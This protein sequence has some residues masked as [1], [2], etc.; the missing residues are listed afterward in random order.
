[1]ARDL[2]EA[3][4]LVVEKG[5]GC[6]GVRACP[7]SG[8]TFTVAARLARYLTSWEPR[9]AGVAALSFTNVAW[10]EIE[11][12]LADEFGLAVP[13]GYPHYLGT[14][15][16]FLNQFIFLPH[17]HRVLGCEKRPRMTGPPYDMREPSTTW[18]PWGKGNAECYRSCHLLDFSYDVTGELRNFSPRSGFAN[19]TKNHEPCTQRKGQFSRAG[20]ATQLDA[21]YYSLTLLANN[22]SLAAALARRFPV[23]VVDEAQDSSAIQMRVLELLADAGLDELLLVGDPDQAIY[24]WRTAD[25]AL[26]EAKLVQWQDES[27]A[28]SDSWR[29]TE[30]LCQSFSRFCT[31]GDPITSVNSDLPSPGKAPE[32]WGYVQ[33]ALPSL[34]ERFRDACE[35]EGVPADRAAVLCRSKNLV[36]ELLGGHQGKP[37]RY[38]PW[39]STFGRSLAVSALQRDEGETLAAF[40]SMERTLAK[41]MLNTPHV[42]RQVLREIYENRGFSRWRS[43]VWKTLCDLP[44]VAGCTLGTWIAGAREAVERVGV[45]DG[46]RVEILADSSKNKYSDLSI[47]QALGADAPQA[48][49]DGIRIGTVHSF[50]G[51]SIEAV[52]LVL[53][54]RAANSKSYEKLL[55][56]QLGVDEEMRIVY[57]AMT[58]ARSLLY[59]AVPD[60]QTEIWENAL[61]V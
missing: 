11:A 44:A 38:S 52:L 2:S 18:L 41:E 30:A 4:K 27:I 15:D 45:C 57:V 20:Y 7:G 60:G 58:R 47:R 6:F 16:G 1:M 40:R 43:E 54:T 10:E 28:F 42:D 29:S 17:G 36:A 12:Y 61:G 34:V 55:N 35:G 3:Q 37:P 13:I 48:V 31:L 24:E 23:I 5:A 51:Q 32:V 14:I 59:L 39:K 50:K 22:P 49:S 21:N 33:D 25:P 26:F 8:K 53:R 9:H 56:G 19:C 46:A